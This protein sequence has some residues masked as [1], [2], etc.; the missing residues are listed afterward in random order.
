MEF[1]ERNMETEV[2]KC[3]IT[4]REL[5]L[6]MN[7]KNCNSRRFYFHRFARFYSMKNEQNLFK[8]TLNTYYEYIFDCPDCNKEWTKKICN[9]SQ[10]DEK[11]T[12]CDDCNKKKLLERNKL[13][14]VVKEPKKCGPKSQ[15]FCDDEDCEFC[16]KRKFSKHPFAEHFSPSNT[17]DINKLSL[18]SHKECLFICPTCKTEDKYRIYNLTNDMI[19]ED[20]FSCVDCKKQKKMELNRSIESG[21]KPTSVVLCNNDKCK[22]CP[23]RKFSKHR[24]AEYYSEKNDKD[25][26]QVMINSG[27]SY[28]FN[29]PDCNKELNLKIS[30][31][32][33]YTEERKICDDCELNVIQQ[34]KEE[35][36]K[37]KLEEELLKECN[38]RSYTLCKNVE[39][40]I[41]EP[42]RFSN[43]HFAKYYNKE[44]NEENVENIIMNSGK[45]YWFYCDTCK[46]NSS[47]S[48]SN[49]TRGDR[50]EFCRYCNN[51]LFCG[52]KECKHCWDRSFA[53]HEKSQYWSTKN[54][55]NPWIVHTGTR[56]K[57][58]FDCY[59]C[60]H[61]FMGR[62]SHI[63]TQG[64]WCPYC[65]TESLCKN[66]ECQIC[67]KLSF[68]SCEKSKYW[69]LKNKDKPHE[70]R[71]GSNLFYL[72]DC[73]ICKHEFEMQPCRITDIKKLT[74]CPYCVSRALCFEEDCKH[75]FERS[76][77]SMYQ[78]RFWSTKNGD[79]TPRMIF[80]KTSKKYIFDCL[81]CKR[82]YEQR[83]ADIYFHN[84]GCSNCLLKTEKLVLLYVDDNTEHIIKRNIKFDWCF[85]PNTCKY[86]PFDLVIE[87][88]KLII[89]IDGDQHFRFVQCFDNDVER[90]QNRD[91]YKMKLALENGYSIIRIV[92]KGVYYNLFDWKPL[93]INAI[94]KYEKPQVI[95][96]DYKC[97]YDIYKEKMKSID[98]VNLDSELEVCEE[99]FDNEE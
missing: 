64:V 22:Y 5:C 78:S 41:C 59:K 77:A 83:P 52:D 93:L 37:K 63:S 18:S 97:E 6:D 36:E 96:I 79:L 39:C 55:I 66:I 49:L 70:V 26:N 57:Y 56:D 47:Q 87:D 91:L 80:K 30:N 45:N 28:I 38:P 44:L 69:S 53:S 25:L 50:T 75:C 81:D 74:W 23:S 95:F 99:V 90:N 62:I 33:K 84:N 4:S 54:E 11:N 27:L 16:P 48:I 72:F 73:D 46:H 60:G 76:F 88:L 58:L 71:L 10:L 42:R 92:Q 20:G 29:C 40:K 12:F 68:A 14:K 17:E 3:K 13:K 32:T 8:V 65:H 67:F 31:I 94:K 24:F 89:E 1:S 35:K 85:N 98:S 15:S 7:C 19:L 9:I 61:E 43:H 86:L 21:C 51:E 82:D 34:K 2:E